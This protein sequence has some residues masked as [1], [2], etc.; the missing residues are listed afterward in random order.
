[1]RRL[2]KETAEKII[3]LVHLPLA[4]NRKIDPSRFDA[5]FDKC[6]LQRA[7]QYRCENARSVNRVK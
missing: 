7:S 5:I 6:Q 4:K 1:L 3:H 2:Y